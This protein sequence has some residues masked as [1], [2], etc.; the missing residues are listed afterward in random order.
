MKCENEYEKK[1][2]NEGY[3]V[4]LGMD[5]AGR[6]PIAGPLVVAGVCFP[7]GYDSDTIYDSKKIS[8]KK[9][10][11][12]FEIIK[13]DSLYFK[14]EIIDESIIDTYNIY[15]TTQMYMEKIAND[16]KICDAILSDAMPLPHVVK[17]YTAL[18]K[19]DQKSVSI[20]AAS[21]L[22][23]VTRDRIMVSY[24]KKYPQYGFKNHKGYPT[25][26]HL[27][28]LDKFG[29]LPIHRKSYGP[30]QRKMQL[31]LDL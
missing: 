2:W 7:Q 14:I 15:A 27:E 19:G 18:I 26:M 23:K 22:A 25:K 16:C 21:I 9:R 10:E 20:A 1:Y 13:E 5:E 12:L 24:D 17:P 29:V 3:Q 8:E 4:V 30:V 31:Q 28:A 6:G 11:E